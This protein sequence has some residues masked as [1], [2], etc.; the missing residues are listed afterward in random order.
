MAI[1]PVTFSLLLGLTVLHQ[2]IFS[3]VKLSN[4]SSDIKSSLCTFPC[5]IVACVAVISAVCMCAVI[6]V[7]VQV[8]CV[9]RHVT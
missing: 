5:P 4:K 7:H 2:M 6:Q 9:A 1:C 3:F 8:L